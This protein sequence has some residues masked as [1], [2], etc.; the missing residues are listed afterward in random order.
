MQNSAPSFWSIVALGAMVPVLIVL[1]F[2]M[3]TAKTRK[4]YARN[5][6]LCMILGIVISSVLLNSGLGPSPEELRQAQNQAPKPGEMLRS[7]PW[8]VFVAGGIWVIGGNYILLRQRR[9]AGESWRKVVNPFTSP[10]PYMNGRSWLQLL[11]LAFLSLALA[12]LGLARH[13]Q[14][15][16]GSALVAQPKP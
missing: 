14:P 7:L 10:V 8:E 1:F 4:G 12:Q 5:F 13:G 11:L 3:M 6:A 16:P 9:K 15:I 2:K